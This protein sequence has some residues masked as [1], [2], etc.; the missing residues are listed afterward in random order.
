MNVL[1]VDCIGGVDR[2]AGLAFLVFAQLELAEALLDAVGC[3][4]VSVVV[5][6]AEEVAVGG[7]EGVAFA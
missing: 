1:D 5:V 4:V 2:E 6:A 3:G 7:K